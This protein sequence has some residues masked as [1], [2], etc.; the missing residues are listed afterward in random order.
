[1]AYLS[2]CAVQIG[3]GG[4]GMYVSS[5]FAA[6]GPQ[7]TWTSHSTGLPAASITVFRVDPFVPT[8]R[9]YAFL[10]NQSIYKRDTAIDDNWHKIMDVAAAIAL[11]GYSDAFTQLSLIARERAIPGTLYSLQLHF[12]FGGLAGGQHPCILNS[13]DYGD[14]WS[15][16]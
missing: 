16:T 13:T 8:Q 2:M 12:D 10:D 5:D 7:P 14:S 6:S 9:Q 1:M 4:G 3:A 15:A 11:T